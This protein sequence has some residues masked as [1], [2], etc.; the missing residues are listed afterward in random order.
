MLVITIC[1][2][3]S[4]T[5]AMRAQARRVAANVAAA[6]VAPGHIA[7]IGDDSKELKE[8]AKVYEAIMP[9]GWKI[10]RAANPALT[11]GG[12]NYKVPAQMLIATMRAEAFT[13]CRQL[14]ATQV[15]SLDSDVLPP[16]NALRCMLSMLE[17]DNGYYSISTCPYPNVAFLGGFGTPQN[18]IAEDFLP[19]E[20]ALPAELK[21]EWEANEA[22]VKSLQ[23]AKQPVTDEH[24]KRWEETTKKIKACPP[25]GNIWQVIQKHGWRRRGWLDH[26]YPA[27]GKGSVVPSDWCG[28]GC[29]LLNTEA[30]ALADFDGYDGQGTEDLFVCWHRWHPAGLRLNVITHCPCDHVIWEKKKGGA[31]SGYT[32]HIAYHEAEGECRGHLRVRQKP[33]LETTALLTAAAAVLP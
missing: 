21:A 33:W 32:H 20:R 10:T 28:F 13:L 31:A 22:E 8:I 12:E 9:D 7:L 19:A 14:G 30:L 4:Y 5:Y 1:A 24:R 26:A 16:A 2:T 18:P 15:W 11:E 17:F 3:K 29:T 23:A 6:K 27:I 25:D